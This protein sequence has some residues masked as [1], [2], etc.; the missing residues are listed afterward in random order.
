MRKG[1][2]VIFSS[3][4][5]PESISQVAAETGAVLLQRDVDFSWKNGIGFAAWDWI[6]DKTKRTAMPIPSLRGQ[7]QLDNAAGVLM[8]VESLADKLPVNQQQVKAALLSVSIPGRFQFIAGEPQH[9]LD[10]AHNKDS[11]ASLAE[12]LGGLVCGGKNIA[13]LGMLD[14]KEH[15]QALEVLLPHIAL[16]HVAD[17]DVPRG[18]KGVYLAKVLQNL[19]KATRVKSFDSVYQAIEEADQIAEPG[20]RV[21]IFGSFFTVELA[22]RLGI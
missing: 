12:L 11:M 18:S 19:D 13:V 7:H 21:I 5:M 4:D 20:D 22:L 9:I 16:W 6:S 3:P 10:V 15:A 1:H 14:D 2:P 17:L 8:V